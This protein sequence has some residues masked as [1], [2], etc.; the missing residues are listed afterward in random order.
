M[1]RVTR[2]TGGWFPAGARLRSDGSHSAPFRRHGG[3]RRKMAGQ[4]LVRGR[5]ENDAEVRARHLDYPRRRRMS[6]V[7]P[8]DEP[9]TWYGDRQLREPWRQW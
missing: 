5:L 6:L 4:R 3:G 2:D 8:V 7:A 1:R 9:V